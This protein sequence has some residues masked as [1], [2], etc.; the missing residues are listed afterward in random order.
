MLLIYSASARHMLAGHDVLLLVRRESRGKSRREEKLIFR[1]KI[2]IMGA[3][4]GG[5]PVSD[6]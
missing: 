1:S 5:A 6:T 3:A 4:R 2:T